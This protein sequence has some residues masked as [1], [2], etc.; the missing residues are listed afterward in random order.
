MML[1]FEFYNHPLIF[2]VVRIVLGIL[3]FMQAYDK[4][5]K[6]GLK[7]VVEAYQLPEKHLLTS[8]FFVW[9]GTVYTSYCELIGGLLLIVGLFTNYVMY[10]LAIDMIIATLG[11]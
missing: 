11:F 7:N 4:V 2:A 5:F 3:F 9:S 8:S 1:D 10:L 6:I